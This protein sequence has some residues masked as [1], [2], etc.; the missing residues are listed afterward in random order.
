MDLL[1]DSLIYLL[2]DDEPQPLVPSIV[3]SHHATGSSVTDQGG[4]DAEVMAELD[5]GTEQR[6]NS[7]LSRLEQAGELC[8]MQHLL[9][10]LQERL[11]GTK[12]DCRALESRLS[13]VSF[14]NEGRD[15]RRRQRY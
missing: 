5:S 4:V 1:E 9:A 2:F 8:S 14:R 15:E 10:A 12:D 7:V 3:V 13:A 11:M 6:L